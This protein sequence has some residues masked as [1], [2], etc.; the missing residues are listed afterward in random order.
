M[1][2]ATII[3]DNDL[4][5]W[6]NKTIYYFHVPLFFICSGYLYQKYSRIKNILDWKNNIIKKVNCAWNTLF[7]IFD[8]NMDTKN[9][10]CRKCE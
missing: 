4:Y 6:F 3:P 5:S 2:K 8:C 9:N 1:V 10:V 7:C